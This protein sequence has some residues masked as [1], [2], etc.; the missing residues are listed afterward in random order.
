MRRALAITALGAALASS[1]LSAPEAN[2]GVTQIKK[3][4]VVDLDR[5]I[6]ESTQGKKAKK[7]L[8]AAMVRSNAKLERKANQLKQRMQDL[9]AKAAMLSQAELVRRQ[10]E[11]L[12]GDQELQQLYAQS[13][14]RLMEKEAL[15]TEKIYKNVQSIVT[16]MAKT[17]RIQV[18]LVRSMATTLYADKK[19]DITNK[20]IVAYDKKFK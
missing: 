10:Q 14:E 8:E 6:L 9:Q 18:V 1:P 16:G 15:L 4:A 3:V 2:A 7:E 11:L 19:L 13:Q 5:C 17:D 20:V 12:A